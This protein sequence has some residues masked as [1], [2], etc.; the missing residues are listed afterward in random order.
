[1]VRGD[2]RD[3]IDWSLRTDGCLLNQELSGCHA[4]PRR[5]PSGSLNLLW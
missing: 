4:F 3:E 1:V 2:I 5:F